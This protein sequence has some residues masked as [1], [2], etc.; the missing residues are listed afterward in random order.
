MYSFPKY[1]NNFKYNIGR[2]GNV[3]RYRK[4][5]KIK[6]YESDGVFYAEANLNGNLMDYNS[7]DI[8]SSFGITNASVTYTPLK[9]KLNDINFKGSFIKERLQYK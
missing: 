1:G 8:K 9:T 5:P 6:D 7:L 2:A 3:L 4:W